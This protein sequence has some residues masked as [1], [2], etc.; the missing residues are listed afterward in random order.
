[1]HPTMNRFLASFLL[2]LATVLGHAQGTMNIYQTNGSILQV[3]LSSIDSVTYQL[4]PPPPL[5]RIHQTGGSILSLA[6][7]QIDSITYSTGGAPGTAQ[8]ATLP[9]TAVGSTTAVCAGTISSDGGST[10]TA[11]GIC[12]G[13]NP[14]PTLGGPSV[15]AGAGLGG[16]QVQLLGLQPNALYYARAYATNG[17]GTA[18]GN[19]VAFSTGFDPGGGVL[20]SVVTAEP[21]SVTSHSATSGGQVS[22]DGGNTVVARGVV[23]GTGPNPTLANSFTV[24]G[25]GMGSFGS[26]LTNLQA[27][28][29]YFVR[30]Y[31]TNGNGT[32]YGGSYQITTGPPSLAGV[33]TDG[34]NGVTVNA[35]TATGTVS[36]QGGV[37]VTERGFCWSTSPNP[38]LQSNQGIVTA[39]SGLGGFVGNLGGLTG[40]TTYYVRAY[41]TNSAGT[42][43]GNQVQFTTSPVPPTVSTTTASSIQAFSANSGGNVSST[44]G[45]AVTQR[46]V[47]WSTTPNPTTAN[48]VTTNGS[49]VGSFPSNL[50]GLQPS[51]TYYVRAYATNGAGTDYGNEVQLTTPS[52]IP[53]LSTTAVSAILATSATSGGSISSDG[54]AAI[55]ARGVCWST[56]PNP[57]T[58][59]NVT[60]NGGGIGSFTSN[61]TGLQ[62]STTYYVRA[63]ATN[64]VTT[65]YGNEVQLTTPIGI[66]VLSTTAVSGITTNSATTGGNI[67]SDG[68]SA[69]TARGVCWSTAPD[70]T[71]AGN[72]TSNGS[73]VGNYASTLTGLTAGAMY[74]VRAYAI[75]SAGT[76]Y[77]NQ[78]QFTAAGGG[79]IVSNPGAGVTFGGYTYATV[80]L[81]NGQEWMAENLRTT[82]YANGAPIPNVTD[83]TAWS[84]LNT[85]A[86]A[87]YMN[88]SSY[89]NP[90]GK[91]YNW[92]AVADPRNVCPTGWHV[93]TV[94]EWTVLNN[95]LGGAGV[96]GGKMKS[97]GTQ[98]WN[99]PN[100]GAT[101]ES[102]FSGLPGGYRYYDGSNFNDGIFGSLGRDGDLWSASESGA[103]DAWTRTLSYSNAALN[104]GSAKKRSGYSVRCLRD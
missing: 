48:S 1:M 84:Q 50:T 61:L 13:T 22:S 89:E 63:Y 98:Y 47:C 11:R 68:G 73:G 104:A 100:T 17:Q 58:A 75:N 3:A 90:Y 46:G 62:P 30:A 34:V 67:S 29:S 69:I 21:F 4:A 56:S 35:A 77:G 38:T 54:G 39:G 80:V 6:I 95:Y 44:G 2:V 45:A 36:H 15:S 25:A 26:S 57:T 96:A 101:N 99:A 28:T 59:N 81:G 33:S 102:D 7:A 41:A 53:V 91:L 49:G 19:V 94:A 70:P 78:V 27:S 82:T 42:Q 60:N 51:T 20:A 103:E 65:A 88:N 8:V 55:T 72:T 16:F 43:Y 86:W 83:N 71:T 74:Y 5:M 40:N 64:G 12:Y 52:G 23:W 97:T 92:Y 9:A 76:A 31:A 24:N 18:Y 87:H 85:G 32:A 14:L 10:V 66:P 79:G 37:T 93:P